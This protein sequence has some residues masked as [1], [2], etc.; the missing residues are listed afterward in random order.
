M[1]TEIL[2]IVQEMDFHN[3]ETQLGLQCARLIAGV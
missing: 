1:S 3:A 2:E